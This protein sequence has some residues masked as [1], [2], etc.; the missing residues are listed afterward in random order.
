M[1]R[2]YQQILDM[3]VPSIT[4]ADLLGIS[5]DLRK[6]VVE[7]CR[8]QRIPAPSA[9]STHAA[10]TD[11]YLPPQVEH[12]T[13][14]RELRVTLNGV[15]SELGL[16]DEGSEIVVI[17][18]DAWRKTNA[19][20]NEQIHM[21]M[22]TANGSSQDMGGCVKMLDI[23]VEGI[24]TWAHAYV[25]PDAPYRLLLGRPWQRLVWLSKEETD[26]A[27][28]VTIHDPWD[29]SNIRV[30]QTLPRPWPQQGSFTTTAVAFATPV[31]SHPVVK[32]PLPIHPALSLTSLTDHL[33]RQAFDYDLVRHVFAYK[34]VANKIKPVTTTMPAHA[35]I[36]RR[37]PEDP[38]LSLPTL[39]PNPPTFVPGVCL[40][41]ERMDQLGIFD[42]KFLWPEEQKLVAH[43]LMNNE[44]ALAWDESEKGRFRDD[45]FP[46]VVIPTIEHTPWV[47][48]QR[49]IPPGL[50]DELVAI[51]KAKIASGVYEPSNSSYQSMWFW[52]EKK[53]GKLRI[54]HNLQPLNSITI[55]DAATLPYVKLF[56]KQSAGCSI[57]IYHDGPICRLQSSCTCRRITQPDH[58]PDPLRNSPSHCPPNGLG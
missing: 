50:H 42:S 4:V 29:S 9:L 51:I 17:R 36:V 58:L 32:T 46:P 47:H 25:V 35:R 2:V 3:V 24:K 34:K 57:Y 49:P 12:A 54:V 39:L 30:C 22:Q 6:E 52:V 40:M 38:L 20:R 33:L 53:N 16:L 26:N 45:Y 44:L 23:D 55:K 11:N 31:S 43:V 15:H 1:Q 5:T 19:L 14:L 48:R 56:T 21:R 10:T 41:Q 8:A 18:E 27:V 7:H 13:P 37:I 28:Q